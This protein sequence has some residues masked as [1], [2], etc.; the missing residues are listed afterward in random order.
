MKRINRLLS[1]GMIIT[2]TVIAVSAPAEVI[3]SDDF[4]TPSDQNW[5]GYNGWSLSSSGSPNPRVTHDST[6]KNNDTRAGVFMPTQDYHTNYGTMIHSLDTDKTEGQFVVANFDV[7]Y[8]DCSHNY[9][10]RLYNSYQYKRPVGI[11]FQEGGIYACWYDPESHYQ[12]YKLADYPDYPQYYFYHAKIEVNLTDTE[13]DGLAPGK[14]RTTWD[15]G[16]ANET[17]YTYDLHPYFTN[18]AVEAIRVEKLQATGGKFGVDNVVVEVIPE[19][20]TMILMSGAL[21]CL[22]IRKKQ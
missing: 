7:Y 18:Y 1:L 3:F 17:S 11:S 14:G 15:V 12:K 6:F 5:D 2:A 13:I 9:N 22:F 4:N 16:G 10:V 21:T 20:A 19:P 8:Q